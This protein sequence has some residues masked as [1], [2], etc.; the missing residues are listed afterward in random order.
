MTIR[1][2][3]LKQLMKHKSLTPLEL[4]LL[5]DIPYS[6]VRARISDLR[7]KGVSI[8]YEYIPTGKYIL[9]DEYLFLDYL[10]KNKLFNRPVSIKQI[11]KG[12]NMKEEDIKMILSKLFNKYSI[13]QVSPEKV[14]INK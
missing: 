9:S 2:D 8:K 1:K 12:S 4:Q 5:N 7:K 3:I 11:S 10:E 13:I 6:S 14:I